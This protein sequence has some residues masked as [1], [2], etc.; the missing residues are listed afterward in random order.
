MRHE[1]LFDEALWLVTGR[2]Q[3]PSSSGEFDLR[4]GPAL[5]LPQIAP[6]R[7][8]IQ[9]RHEE[10]RWIYRGDLSL[11]GDPPRRILNLIEV[12]PFAPGAE[13]TTWTASDPA[14][15]PLEGTF[16]RVDDS[17]LN[18]Y[19]S[20]AGRFSG[21]EVFRQLEEGIVDVRGVLLEGRE[22]TAQWSLRLRRD[23]EEEAAE[24]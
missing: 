4:R 1:F 10:E 22:Q 6:L 15:G 13:T 3:G 8:E 5:P 16:S 9:I 14:L 2:W 24:D 17:L 7:G 21:V 18:R 23:S 20:A 11:P 19:T 12:R